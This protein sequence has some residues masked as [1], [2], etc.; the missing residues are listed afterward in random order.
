MLAER[1][2]GTT[3]TQFMDMTADRRAYLLS[4]MSVEGQI[5]KTWAEANNNLEPGTEVWIAEWEYDLWD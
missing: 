1:F 4:V 2:P 3:P 5:N